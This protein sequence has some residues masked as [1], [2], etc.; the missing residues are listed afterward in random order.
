MIYAE[1]FKAYD[2]FVLSQ[3]SGLDELRIKDDDALAIDLENVVIDESDD[4]GIRRIT[5][6]VRRWDTPGQIAKQFGI[7][8]KNLKAVNE[9][10][11]DTLKPWQKLIIT[12]VEWF[13]IENTLGNLTISQYAAHFG[14]DLADL[15]ELNDI[16][17]DQDIV[18]SWYEL[19]IPL[20]EEEGIRLWMI[21]KEIEPI[22][23]PNNTTKPKN[24]WSSVVKKPA[25]KSTT[26]S[27]TTKE[28][29]K[30]G[31][32]YYSKNETASYLWFAAWNCTAYVARKKPAIAKAIREEWWW[33]AKRR[34][35]QASEAWLKV[36][37]KP[38]IWSIWVMWTRYG[39][40][41]HVGIV[42][43]VSDDE[44]CMNNANV[45]GRWIVSQDCFPMKDF[46]WFIY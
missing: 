39:W 45:R 13:V 35:S 46:I 10:V 40:Y 36:G 31:K 34:Y 38:T 4:L 15:K 5:Y 12:P 8:T 28:V 42:S 30:V 26:A 27:R 16:I 37:K 43:S 11:N 24:N 2:N 41:G 23:Q 3:W 7:T 6:T 14:L 1:N 21:E 32:A 17:S 44:V 33:H 20:T 22:V 9:L 19:F 18:K 25:A 29:K